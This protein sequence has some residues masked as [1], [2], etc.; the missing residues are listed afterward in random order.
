MADHVTEAER[1]LEDDWDDRPTVD[2][3]ERRLERLGVAGPG[4]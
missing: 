2:M 4:H 3:G 1:V